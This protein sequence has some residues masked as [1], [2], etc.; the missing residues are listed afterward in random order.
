MIVINLE[1]WVHGDP[2]NT[3]P[4]GRAYIANAGT[5]TQELGDYGV[6]ICRRGSTDVP[7]PFRSHGPRAV[8]VGSVT[9]YPR[10]AYNIWRLIARA[11]LAAFPEEDRGKG[12]EDPNVAAVI[13]LAARVVARRAEF[14]SHNAIAGHLMDEL[15]LAVQALKNEDQPEKGTDSDAP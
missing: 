5:G 7:Y 2:K 11:T 10:K 13:A 8:R 4:L 6:V 3:Y 15:V 14:T 9:R 12:H 1:M